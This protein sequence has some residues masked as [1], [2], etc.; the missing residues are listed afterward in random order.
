M[1]GSIYQISKNKKDILEMERLGLILQTEGNKTVIDGGKIMTNSILTNS[2]SANAVTANEI[3]A[4]TII[5]ENIKAGSIDVSRLVANSILLPDTNYNGVLIN[6]TGMKITSIANEILMNA[7]AG[8]SI[9]NKLT[10]KMVFSVNPST[11]NIEMDVNKLTINASNVATE[12]FTN[13]KIET[14]NNSIAALSLKS[15]E[16]I[17]SV[18]STNDRIDNIKQGGRNLVKWTTSFERRTNTAWGAW[19]TASPLTFNNFENKTTIKSQKVKTYQE[20]IITP[21]GLNII[22]EKDY[23]LTFK[24]RGTVSIISAYVIVTSGTNYKIKSWD[25]NDGLSSTDFKEFSVKFKFPSNYNP[26]NYIA[27]LD[28]GG[29]AL[30][31]WIEILGESF[32]FTEGEGKEWSPAPEDLIST[33]GGK[34][35]V[36]NSQT[37]NIYPTLMVDGI[38]RQNSN[39]SNLAFDGEWVRMVSNSATIRSSYDIGT[40]LDTVGKAGW[41]KFGLDNLKIGDSLTF[42]I[43]INHVAGNGVQVAMYIMTNG[44]WVSYFA[45][46][47]A[48]SAQTKKITVSA[49]IIAGMTGVLCRV[50]QNVSMGATTRFKCAQLEVGAPATDWKPAPEDIIEELNNTYTGGRNLLLGTKG[51]YEYA[52]TLSTS[53][54]LKE[55]NEN[56]TRLNVSGANGYGYSWIETKLTKKI[57]LNKDYIISADIRTT[58]TANKFR[59]GLRAEPAASGVF[60]DY[61]NTSILNGNNWTRVSVPFKFTGNYTKVLMLIGGD[62][63]GMVI[64]LKNIQLEEGNKSSAW[65]VAPEESDAESII[66][67]IGGRNMIANSDFTKITVPLAAN[68]LA[69]N[70]AKWVQSSADTSKNVYLRV[71]VDADGMFKYGIQLSTTTP[72]TVGFGVSQT[73]IIVRPL[74]KYVVTCWYK[75]TT[76]KGQF[77]MQVGEVNTGYQEIVFNAE[78]TK[79]NRGIFVFETKDTASP[80]GLYLGLTGSALTEN[81]YLTGVQMELGEYPTEW[82][83]SEED[84]SGSLNGIINNSGNLVNNSSLTGTKERWNNAA[85]QIVKVPFN[86][87]TTTEEIPVQQVVSTGNQQIYSDYFSIDPSKAYE[88]SMWIKTDTNVPSATDYMGIFPINSLG[89]RNTVIAVNNSDGVVTNEA[90]NNFYFHVEAPSGHMEWKKFVGYIMPSGTNPLSMK[91]IGTNITRN[92]IFKADTVGVAFRWLNYYNNTSTRGVSVAHPK[93][94]EVSSEQILRVTNTESLIQQTNDRIGLSVTEINESINA[95]NT[96]VG[97]LEVKSDNIK[98]QIGSADYSNLIPMGDFEEN[99]LNVASPFWSNSVVLANADKINPATGPNKSNKVLQIYG[100]AT[101]NRD[102]EMRDINGNLVKIKTNSG[103]KYHFEM[104]VRWPSTTQVGSAC[105]SLKTFSADG[106]A[107]GFLTAISD[108]SKT[109]WKKV[110]GVYTIPEGVEYVRPVVSYVGAGTTSERIYVDNLKIVRKMNSN[111]IDPINVKTSINL[112]ESGVQIIGKNIDLTGYV[113]FNSMDDSLKKLTSRDAPGAINLNTNFSDWTGALPTS[114]SSI[115]GK[116]PEKVI[117]AVNGGYRVKWSLPDGQTAHFTQNVYDKPYYQYIAVDFSFL[118]ASGNIQGAGL[119][120]RWSN[121]T[122]GIIEDAKISFKSLFPNPTLNKWYNASVVVKSPFPSS[123]TFGGY[124]I[125]PMGGWTSIESP[126]VALL[127]KEISFGSVMARPASKEEIT[128]YENGQTLTEW[129]TPG[130]TTING[131]K[132]TTNSIT[133][134]SIA[135]NAITANKIEAKAITA[136]KLN[137][138]TLDA[139]TANMGTVTAGLIRVAD[140][141]FYIDLA[142]RVYYSQGRT[143]D[144]NGTFSTDKLTISSGILK[145]DTTVE[146]GFQYRYF[147]QLGRGELNLQKW[148]DRAGAPIFSAIVTPDGI[149]VQDIG[150]NRKFLAFP[151]SGI[152]R[153]KLGQHPNNSSD[154]PNSKDAILQLEGWQPSLEWRLTGNTNVIPDENGYSARM[155]V[156]S[157]NKTTS[158]NNAAG[159][160][161]MDCSDVTFR[162]SQFG[163]ETLMVGNQWRGW[164]GAQNMY[165]CPVGGSLIIRD[166]NADGAFRPIA[167]SAFNVNSER[168]VKENIVDFKDGLTLVDNLKVRKYNRKADLKNGINKEEVG[169]ILDES[170]DEMSVE[171]V[172]INLYPTLAIALRAIQQLS[173]KVKIL[174]SK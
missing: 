48:F 28:S 37:K 22:K 11:G 134:N 105:L 91:N 143:A 84:L 156:A 39:A 50:Y 112:D 79:W 150:D 33:S 124:N 152:N 119:L 114:Y 64:D 47:A 52:Y 88:F 103:D 14:V 61:Q 164:S 24:A 41:A 17:L 111:E 76:V 16:I 132:I 169:L 174:E 138:N 110:T 10:S 120:L 109:S 77:K 102:C 104:W 154:I 118:L 147:T 144:T 140:G 1:K 27:I 90:D 123:T 82:K 121:T 99:T 87:G 13:Q 6:S 168:K 116:A 115:V 56:Y 157:S 153:W 35:Y 68:S 2:I 158:T 49:E 145:I 107:M 18:K 70:W 57:E 86:N 32:M 75:F 125:F 5:S 46:E 65:K 98:L 96:K 78:N 3:A 40:S 131:G 43:D 51:Y 30:G 21:K 62:T 81:F 135:A 155:Y 53:Q 15:D 133:S 141:S 166:S 136:D 92:A 31:E 26:S 173:E 7:N 25:A 4:E 127:A 59:F 129:T 72:L 66:G 9:Y 130:T 142:N 38:K 69:D 170:P 20:G 162:T 29:A 45:N 159:R 85:M 94:V 113:T 137:V 171:G 93:V 34:N 151:S 97:I 108:S 12:E 149:N 165:V 19:D 161:I 63:A 146:Q 42:S 101:G 67:K 60:Y 83:R 95:T 172:G 167:A 89:I 122:G 44:T 163:A 74:T 54:N 36:R 128:A 106:T 80:I 58:N 23:T 148:E 73:G 8:L 126:Q 71:P 100:T 117:D 55:E 160:I 139:I